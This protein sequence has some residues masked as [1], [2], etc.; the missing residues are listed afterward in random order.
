M[1]NSKLLLCC[2]TGILLSVIYPLWGISQLAWF[3]LIPLCL[4]IRQ[5]D[6]P[7]QAARYTFLAGFIFFFLSLHWLIHVILVGWIFVALFEAAFWWILGWAAWYVLKRKSILIRTFSFALCWMMIEVFRADIPVL[8]LGW[9]LLAYSQSGHS[10][11]IQF[12]NL[13]GVYGLSFMM[14]WINALLAEIVWDF[15]FEKQKQTAKTLI[16]GLAGSALLFGFVWGYGQRSLKT[17]IPS[18]GEIRVSLIQGN[19]PQSVKWEVM[20][21]DQIMEIYFKLT[22][23]AAYES[24]D[25]IVWPEASFPGYFN[26]DPD[27]RLVE[28]WIDQISV[29]TLIGAPYYVDHQTVHNSAY[30]VNASGDIQQRYD[31]IN[32]VPFGEYVP[33]GN[34]LS[35]LKPLAESLGVSDFSPGRELTT[36]KLRD[37]LLFSVLICFEDVFPNLVRRFARR[38]I[39]F[40]AVMTNDAWF[41]H[42]GAPYQHLQASVFR[43]V[44]NGLPIVRSANTGVSAFI[45][46]RGR[47]LGKVKG[48]DGKEIFATG[49]KTMALPLERLNTLYLRGGWVFPYAGAILFVMILLVSLRLS[50]PKPE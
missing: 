25:L 3:A 15:K 40:L 32:L 30:L 49:R 17:E 46:A 42:T 18:S 22:E 35:L 2:L 12:A 37:N 33:F 6:H 44:E 50:N 28:D 39:Q 26:R 10:A 21:R 48:R 34:L 43:A 20:A 11:L 4:M 7:V 13:G 14:A 27:G 31:K 9:N 23:L 41:G 16:I 29:P 36:F 47:V 1:R 19:I 8:S 45:D 38:D 5:C 24:P